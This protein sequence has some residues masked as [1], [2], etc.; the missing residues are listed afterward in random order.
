M[1]HIPLFQNPPA[2]NPV[3]SSSLSI[4]APRNTDPLWTRSDSS[5]PPSSAAVPRSQASTNYS[6]EE[7]RNGVAAQAKAGGDSVL[8]SAAPAPSSVGTAVEKKGVG[9]IGEERKR[10]SNE[11]LH[12]LS[13]L[14]IS[15]YQSTY[16]L[17]NLS[18]PTTSPTASSIPSTTLPTP[19]DPSFSHYGSYNSAYT[20]DFDAYTP[21][22]FK[23]NTA[24]S[25]FDTG[26]N[27]YGD[28]KDTG[29]TAPTLLHFNPPSSINADPSS[30]FASS[31]QAAPSFSL[32]P[33]NQRDRSPP[34]ESPVLESPIIG[35]NDEAWFGASS[36]FPPN[37]AAYRS[38]SATR[39]PQSQEAAPEI[40]SS[41]SAPFGLS[42]R[43]S[44]AH[45]RPSIDE[46]VNFLHLLQPT[47]SPPYEHL[48]SRIVHASDQQASIFLQQKL[49]I[50][51]PEMR[52]RILEAV[53]S[54]GFQMMTNRFGNWAVQ[55]CL[56][57]PCTAADRRKVALAMKGRVVELAMNCYGT[58][59]VQK[60]L[61]CEEDIRLLVLSELLYNDPA[62]TLVNKHASHV[63]SK[64]MEL[65][66]EHTSPPPP[67][68]ARVNAALRGKWVDLACHETGSLVVQH[69]FE[70]LDERE[71]EELVEEVLQGFDRVVKDQWGSWVIQHLL[72]HGAPYHK[73]RAL[74][75]L[76]VGIASYATD[77]NAQKSIEKALKCGVDDAVMDELVKRLCEPGH[78]GRRAL[79]VDLALN[80]TGSQLI[81]QILPF[82]NKDQRASLFNA[83]KRHTV[84]LKGSKSGSRVIYLFDRMRSY[85]G[86]C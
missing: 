38:S 30:R 40:P 14:T 23:S 15:D 77:T 54:K 25:S 2:A 12:T 16:G 52:E 64:I 74:S 75:L 84:T 24:L 32:P 9:A 69:A 68:F 78:T 85:Y 47:S 27:F 48:V 61:D 50:A 72:E 49:K 33:W 29:I 51:T 73:S 11:L 76:L 31:S 36:S 82:V 83:I 42:S 5:S 4:W 7:W 65:T 45:P 86:N 66:W 37:Y 39:V 1:Y 43:T 70:N 60:A 17:P 20:R 18:T 41:R 26:A 34:V 6:T 21:S 71:I 46:P 80:A 35:K 67:I 57:P 28:G 53:L 81:S 79:L 22:K 63:W 55:R 56:E 8:F 59:V 58:H 19:T 3:R 13:S 10:L 62:T 44:K